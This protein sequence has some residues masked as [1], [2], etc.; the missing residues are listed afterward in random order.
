[1]IPVD[2]FL[3]SAWDLHDDARAHGLNVDD[4][5]ERLHWLEDKLDTD[6]AEVDFARS[7]ANLVV[8]QIRDALTAVKGAGHVQAVADRYADLNAHADAGLGADELGTR[9]FTRICE[10]AEL[11]RDSKKPPTHPAKNAVEGTTSTH[12]RTTD[13]PSE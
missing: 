2:E 12:E 10:R 7:S 1:M 9:R 6:P 13:V 8:A 3:A 4:L 5:R 11:R